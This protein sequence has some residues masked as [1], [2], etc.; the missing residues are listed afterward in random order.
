MQQNLIDVHIIK[1]LHHHDLTDI[2]LDQCLASI[3]NEPINVFYVDPVKDDIRQARRNG[4]EQGDAPYVSFVDPDD[5]IIPGGFDVC[6][7]HINDAVC[8]VYTT[9][10]R[11]IGN[12]LIPIHQFRPYEQSIILNNLIEI[13]QLVVMDRKIVNHVLNTYYDYIPPIV[14]EAPCLYALMSMFKPWLAIDHVGY[15][16]RQHNFNPAHNH[17]L[18]PASN[19]SSVSD[20][21][22]NIRSIIA[23]YNSNT[24]Q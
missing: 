5:Y 22:K 24:L 7:K 20:S 8:G 2:W 3:E 1:P 13:H 4:F 9:S 21:I 6:L 14:L 11:L 18:T 15:V 23:G 16:W 10:N 19:A 17:K 12:D